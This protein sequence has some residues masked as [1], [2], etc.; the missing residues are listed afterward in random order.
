MLVS[1]DVFRAD[2]FVLAKFRV[3]PFAERLGARRGNTSILLYGGD[4]I[5]MNLQRFGDFVFLVHVYE[6]GQLFMHGL[7]DFHAAFFIQ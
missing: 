6:I 1:N 2:R 5:R 4:S 3:E 7:H